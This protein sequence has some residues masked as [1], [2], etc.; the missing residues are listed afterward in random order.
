MEHRIS[1]ARELTLAKMLEQ[2][3]K[4]KGW[5]FLSMGSDGMLLPDMEAITHE[6]IHNP[7]EKLVLL[8]NMRMFA[9][10][11]NHGSKGISRKFLLA[12]VDGATK[13]D[14][15]SD[16]VETQE[17]QL[18]DQLYDKLTRHWWLFRETQMLKT[19]WYYPSQKDFLQRV[20][21]QWMGRSEIQA[22]L[23]EAALK[24]KIAA[25][26]QSYSWDRQG[27]P[28]VSLRRIL[29]KWKQSGTSIT[30][31]LTPQNAKFLGKAWDKASIDANSKLLAE[32]ISEYTDAKLN[33]QDWSERYPSKLFL[34]H[35]HLTVNGNEQ[36]GKDLMEL[37][38]MEQA[39]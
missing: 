30:V 13:R 24:L 9:K 5:N 39:Q 7:P 18:S 38:N 17:S 25:W 14:L 32:V 21:E 27:L 19:L 28:M 37:M 36:Y 15:Q 34:D 8:L 31:I 4:D 29:D 16:L 11:F 3:M 1:K 12:E 23:A 6:T 26:Y 20:V 10:E 35:C 22:T 33:F 2:K